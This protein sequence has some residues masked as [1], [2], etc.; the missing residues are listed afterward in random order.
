MMPPISPSGCVISG[1]RFHE[2][3]AHED[4][5]RGFVA[6]ISIDPDTARGTIVFYELPAGSLMMVPGVG[7]E[8]TQARGPRDFKVTGKRQ[9]TQD[10]ANSLPFPVSEESDECRRVRGVWT[11][12]WTPVL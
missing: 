6:E 4:D 12:R 1:M 10:L 5:V 2:M 9:R 11:P 7:F 3:P 8:P